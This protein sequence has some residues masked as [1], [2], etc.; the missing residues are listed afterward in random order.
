M[1]IKNKLKFILKKLFKRQNKY[2]EFLS[3][4]STP[5]EIRAAIKRSLK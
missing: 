5:A 3:L 2:E 1:T 4:N